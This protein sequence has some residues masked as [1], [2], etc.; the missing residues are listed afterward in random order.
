MS[1]VF[2]GD[3]NSD[4][5]QSIV[6]AHDLFALSNRYKKFWTLP[7]CAAAHRAI[8]LLI[9]KGVSYDFGSKILQRIQSAIGKK[10]FTAKNFTITDKKLKEW[11]LSSEKI[12]GIRQILA[13][14]EQ[15]EITSSVLCKVKAGGLYL[16]KAFKVFSEENDDVFMAEDYN[17]QQ[18][19]GILLFR[20]KKMTNTEA[21]RLSR[22][23]E[24][25]RSRISYFLY[26]LKPT[27][28]VKI[29]DEEDLE[30][31]DFW[32]CEQP[33]A[34]SSTSSGGGKDEVKDDDSSDEAPELVDGSKVI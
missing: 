9:Y 33:K 13:L 8:L 27:G 4:V 11:G 30:P 24:G 34:S 21:M 17:V 2:E 20:T 23:W 26:R 15:G 3:N 31:W 14:A 22:T 6:E 19:M 32:G 12:E 28:A 1:D 18:N 16:V 10:D 7:E 29:L 25:Y 5:N